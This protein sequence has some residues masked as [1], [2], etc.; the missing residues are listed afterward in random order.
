LTV[1]PDLLKH[2]ANE[3]Y[4]E[5][6]AVGKRWHRDDLAPDGRSWG[7]LVK[8]AQDNRREWFDGFFDGIFGEMEKTEKEIEEEMKG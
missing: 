1:R 6:Y 7:D 2:K 4:D 3:A 8:T 5:G